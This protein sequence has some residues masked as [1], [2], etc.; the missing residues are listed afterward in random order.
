MLSNILIVTLYN[1]FFNT[2]IQIN[3][4]ADFWRLEFQFLSVPT[5]PNHR[6]Q[7]DLQEH[8][9]TILRDTTDEKQI[10]YCKLI[11]HCL[12]ETCGGVEDYIH[13]S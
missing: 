9:I 13:Q 5:I 12:M 1:Y 6:L 11:K 3:L 7:L 2:F 10:P 4:T 8:P